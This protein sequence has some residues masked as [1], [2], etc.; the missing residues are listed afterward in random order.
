VVSTAAADA[1]PRSSAS[2]PPG[3][4]GKMSAQRRAKANQRDRVT[5]MPSNLSKEAAS[6]VK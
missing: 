4:D 3:T 1:T 6:V 2:P 5:L